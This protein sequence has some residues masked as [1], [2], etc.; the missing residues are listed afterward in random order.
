[1]VYTLDPGGDVADGVRGIARD[2][3]R[4]ARS[5]LDEPGDDLVE[6]IHDCRKRCKKLRGLARLVRPALVGEQYEIANATFR[7]AARELSTLRDAHALLETFDAVC[8]AQRHHLPD[9]GLDG[10]RRRLRTRS[11]AATRAA[12]VD[13]PRVA[14]ALDLLRHGETLIEGWEL[15]AS[16]FDAL[17][18]GLHKTYRR[19]RTALD[20]A[21]RSPTSEA[22]HEYRKR[23]KYTWYHVRL[24]DATAPAVLD[25][26]EDRLHH[27]SDTLGD[28]H[29]LAV[30]SEQLL[31]DPDAFAGR[32]QV[33]AAMI[34][35][36]GQRAD[37]Q[38]RALAAGA[39]LHAEKPKAFVKRIRAY[40]DAWHE[41][42]PELGTGE[43][44]AL[45]A[46]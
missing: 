46:Q 28:D 1:M 27:L 13:D 36:D 22:F 10:V 37:L 38:R 19:G 8:D 23:V 29:D 5:D 9:D 35:I 33:A 17:A 3:V 42:G 18:G 41:H 15:E 26:L 20:E 43:I 2:Q 32:E 40:W 16:G 12:T 25:P 45:A 24:L 7:D 21:A 14:A 6:A 30:L 11:A 4:I 39:R 44:G 31:A 34:V